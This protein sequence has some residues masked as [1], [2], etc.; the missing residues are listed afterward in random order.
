MKK[1]KTGF[2]AGFLGAIILI[3]IMFL[4]E[5]LKIAGKP[6]FVG[7]YNH[8][9]GAHNP[10][11]SIPIAAFLFAVSGGIWGAIFALLLQPEIFRGI[12]FGILPSLWVWLVIAP[13]MGQP[14]FNG[15]A[16]KAIIFPLIFNCLIWGS[17]IGWYVKNNTKG[18]Y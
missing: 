6:G 15:F 1:L 11:Y 9:F 7:I 8:T 5:W 14:L 12:L 4:L 10:V 18:R 2:I 3:A 17:F 16:P 13:Y